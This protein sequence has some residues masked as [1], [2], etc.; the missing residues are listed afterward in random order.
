MGLPRPDGVG[1][2]PSP[3]TTSLYV[4][5]SGSQC[6]LIFTKTKRRSQEKEKGEEREMSKPTICNLWIRIVY[7]I[8]KIV[9]ILSRSG[10]HGYESK[11]KNLLASRKSRL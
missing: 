5:V 11:R 6:T 9:Y 4:G 10:P 2:T 8:Y 1:K 7:R 3:K